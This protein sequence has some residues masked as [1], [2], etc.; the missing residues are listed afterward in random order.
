MLRNVL[1]ARVR[2][3]F[4]KLNVHAG[5]KTLSLYHLLLL[6]LS[7]S[8]SLFLSLFNPLN[9]SLLSA[10]TP[11]EIKKFFDPVFAQAKLL[12]DVYEKAD[13]VKKSKIKLPFVTVSTY[14]FNHTFMDIFFTIYYNFFPGV[15]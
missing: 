8:L 7:L 9:P 12:S 10:L 4:H 3:T 15:P 5:E 13:R 6:S 2:R 14:T 1:K 11:D